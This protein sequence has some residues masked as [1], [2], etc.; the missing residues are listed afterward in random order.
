M[1]KY[2]YLIALTLILGLVLTGCTLLSNI[3]QVPTNEQSGISYLT[4]HTEDAPQETT[5]FAGQ[6]IP[7]GTV[8]VW[9]DCI[10]LYVKYETTG[11]WVMTETHLAVVTD[12]ADFPTNKP[13]NP[14]V[15]L[16]PYGEENIFTNTWEQTIEL[17]AISEVTGQELFIAAHA[18]VL[19]ETATGL[20]DNLVVNGGFELPIVSSWAVFADSYPGL[21]WTVEPTISP[22]DSGVPQG[23][24]LQRLSPPHSGLQYA[25]L[26][27]YDPVRIWQYLSTNSTKGS[28]TLTY[29]WSPRPG[30]SENIMEVWWDNRKIATHSA[31]GIGGINW[32]VETYTGLVPNETA[33]TRLE[34]VETGPDDQL[35]MFLDSVSV[36][37]E[38]TESAWADGTRFT[39]KGNWAT[40]S[41]YTVQEVLIDT[42]TV[43]PNGT[44]YY[45]SASLEAGENYRIEVNGTISGTYTYWPAELPAAGIA[46]A[47]YSLR[48]E[49]SFNLG[50]GPQ[51]ISGDDLP[52]PWTHYLELLVNGSSQAWGDFT[53]THTYSMEYVS[54]GSSVHFNILDSGYGDNSGFLT[55]D[56]YCMP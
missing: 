54:T 5:L 18:V 45:S 4:K 48:P 14:K 21:E 2:Y 11:G 30:V 23:L 47:K 7:V 12:L 32:T 22:W 26:D 38:D 53:E 43:Y 9:N 56:I 33:I 6:D 49:G 25:E 41:T 37:Q 13:G 36:V 15:G 42:V 27:A 39:K 55:V 50:P 10:N 24:E 44:F 8:S 17:K 19:N 16:F 35:G 28:Y 51:W 46:D 29:A 3:G 20:G 40:Y 52:T 31:D 1:K 34:F